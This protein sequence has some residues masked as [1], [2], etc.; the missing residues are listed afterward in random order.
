MTPLPSPQG[1]E[2]PKRHD[3]VGGEWSPLY[4]EPV[5]GSGE[6]I[7]IGVAAVSDSAS[8]VVPVVALDRLEC[9]YGKGVDAI[10]LASRVA[11][12]YTRNI[13]DRHGAQALRSWK[14]PMDGVYLGS[15]V[16][17]EADTLE[18]IARTGLTASS[19]LVEKLA[20]AEEEPEGRGAALTTNRLEELVKERVVALQP[21]LANRFRVQRRV[22]ENARAA[23][24]GFIGDRIAA[25]FGMLLPGRLGP[26]VDVSKAKLWDLA[27]LR[28]DV[29]HGDMYSAA[30][31]NRFELFV[32]RPRDETPEYSLRQMKGIQE[33]VVELEAEA[34][35]VEIRCR[36]ATSHEEIAD[37][38]LQAEAA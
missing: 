29:K 17:S 23:V 4:I 30:A 1:I 26:L 13:L 25:N 10:M 8:L 2:F 24:I 12:E 18:E 37:K 35:K 11:L 7:C 19:S 28:E 36:P 3:A 33:A 27:Q 16:R 9:L 38:L 15:A 14:A 22:R 34:D 5:V 31:L 6:R 32:Y 20:D 21:P